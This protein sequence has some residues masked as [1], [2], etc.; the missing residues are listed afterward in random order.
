M[1]AVGM[2]SSALDYML[3]RLYDPAR[4]TFGKPLH[5]HGSLREWVARS[6]IEITSARL[7]VLNAA[8]QI[9]IGGAKSALRQIAMAKVIVPNMTL[10]VIDR[11][12]QVH[13]AAGICQ[14]FPLARMWAGARTL[15]LADGPDEVHLDQ[16][17]RLEGRR[18]ETVKK[19]FEDQAVRTEKL[20]KEHASTIKSK[21]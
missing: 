3:A 19:Q 18:A 14:D 5:S 4:A 20:L 12:M 2:A 21:L 8:Q 10:T 6:R 9:D 17:G 1:R 11:A 16:L 7:L 13:G 15:R